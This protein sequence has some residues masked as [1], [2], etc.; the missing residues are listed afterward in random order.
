MTL[1]KNIKWI[2]KQQRQLTTSIMHLAQELLMSIEYSGGS[3]SFAKE[4]GALKLKETV[5]SHPK[6]TPTN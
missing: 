4:M 5:A 1:A 6:M 2:V 3:R